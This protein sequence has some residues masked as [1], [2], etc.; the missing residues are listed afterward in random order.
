MAHCDVSADWSDFTQSR[1]VFVDADLLSTLLMSMGMACEFHFG[2]V[3][4]C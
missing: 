3:I 1:C 2:N 4:Y